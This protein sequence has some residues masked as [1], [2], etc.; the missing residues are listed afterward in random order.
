MATSPLTGRRARVLASGLALALVA[1][2]VQ[3][4][5]GPA[6]SVARPAAP[7]VGKVVVWQDAHG[8]VLTAAPGVADKRS[9]VAEKPI[10]VPAARQDRARTESGITAAAEAPY[11]DR[12]ERLYPRGTRSADPTGTKASTLEA[13]GGS[14]VVLPFLEYYATWTQISSRVT[15]FGSAPVAADSISHTDQWHV[16]FVGTGYDVWGA[17]PGASITTGP[18]WAD[19]KWT[20]TVDDNWYSEHQWDFLAFYPEDP[21]LFGQIYRMQHSVSGV[22][23]F[24]SSFHTVSGDARLFT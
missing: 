15:W 13:A 11:A 8:R 9:L 7:P 19:V 20:S 16:D 18:S 21:P 23:Q 6:E 5:V 4:L 14:H 2:T 12:I 1:T 22:F 10:A 24:G 17:P 3:L